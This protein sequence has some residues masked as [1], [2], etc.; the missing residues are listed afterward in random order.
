MK[1]ISFR[2]V[3]TLSPD[4]VADRV[5]TAMRCNEDYAIIPSYFQVLLAAKW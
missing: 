5:I 3:P 1:N 2:F 4:E